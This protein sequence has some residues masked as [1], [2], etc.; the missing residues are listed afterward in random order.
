MSASIG[1]ALRRAQT[2]LAALPHAEP[3]LEAALLLARVLGRPRTYLI[4]WPER[5][6]DAGQTLAFEVLVRR[7]CAGEP[8]AYITGQREFWSLDLEVTPDTLIPR[9]E[10]ELLVEHALALIPPAARWRV[11]DLGTGS[12]AVAAALARERPGCRI[13]ATDRSARALAVASRNFRRIGLHNVES[14]R[15]SWWKAFA[16][17]ERLDLVASNP[18]Y[19]AAGDSHLRRG[20]LRREPRGA[21]DGGADGTQAL[22]GIAAGARR[23]LKRGGWLLLEH[24]MA[25]GPAV[26]ALMRR[27]GFVAV[28]SFRDA[29]RHVR[30]TRGR[31]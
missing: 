19:L 30:V 27:H 23:H 4:A 31:A 28:T 6:L 13:L 14:R 18:P 1:E 20:D 15:G 21:L 26:R 29:A 5:T 9:P 3:A 8:I 17:R 25:Q 10:T 12:G 22:R 11:A 7:R 2:R 16:R 24:G